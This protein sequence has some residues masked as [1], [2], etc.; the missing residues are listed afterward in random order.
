MCFSPRSVTSLLL[1]TPQTYHFLL[2][3][4]AVLDQAVTCQRF[5]VSS[6]IIF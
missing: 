2:V 5:L 6:A 4:D 1:Y 3:Q